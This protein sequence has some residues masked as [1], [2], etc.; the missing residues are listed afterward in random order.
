LLAGAR[1]QALPADYVAWLEALPLAID[2]REAAEDRARR[3]IKSSEP[4]LRQ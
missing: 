4:P 2:E 1:E 3:T